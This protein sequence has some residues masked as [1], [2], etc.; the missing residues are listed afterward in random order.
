VSIDVLILCYI[1][2]WQVKSPVTSFVQEIILSFHFNVHA[3]S[4]NVFALDGIILNKSV[5]KF[6]D[7]FCNVSMLEIFKSVSN[8]C[9]VGGKHPIANCC[10]SMALLCSGSAYEIEKPMP[11]SNSGMIN[12]A[13][14]SDCDVTYT[15][16]DYPNGEL[17]DTSSATNLFGTW[18]SIGDDDYDYPFGD[19]P[20]GEY[21]V[22][23]FGPYAYAV[24]SDSL[25]KLYVSEWHTICYSK[26]Q[27]NFLPTEKLI[28]LSQ[29][30]GENVFENHC[31]ETMQIKPV[32]IYFQI[33]CHETNSNM[34]DYE[35]RSSESKCHSST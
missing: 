35:V 14:I 12:V 16:K 22:I 20:D 13:V 6:T 9:A 4:Y 34:Y 21:E 31:Q 24:E 1:P 32:P 3:K 23:K 10:C 19:A 11:L 28:R 7:G 26:R 5:L 29:D 18:N 27:S 30:F 33:K 15:T 2:F 8:Q 17:V 25:D